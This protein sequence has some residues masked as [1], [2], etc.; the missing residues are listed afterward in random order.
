MKTEIKPTVESEK[1]YFIAVDDVTYYIGKKD[2]M[3]R[4]YADFYNGRLFKDV[5]KKYW[6]THYLKPFDDR[7]FSEKFVDSPL[8]AFLNA[9]FVLHDDSYDPSNIDFVLQNTT[10]DPDTKCY[11][12][13]EYLTTGAMLHPKTSHWQKFNNKQYELVLARHEVSVMTT[14]IETFDLEKA[15]RAWFTTREKICKECEN[16]SPECLCGKCKV[17]CVNRH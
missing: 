11:V 2:E 9:I 12:F 7:H 8:K 13:N 16:A 10:Y 14:N 17:D 1:K 6:K 4:M 3:E 15:K 5:D